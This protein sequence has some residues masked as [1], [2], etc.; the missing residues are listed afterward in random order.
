ML[1]WKHGEFDEQLLTDAV[2]D[3]ALFGEEEIKLQLNRQFFTHESNDLP[4]TKR[5]LFLTRP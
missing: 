1:N 4:T 3:A 5:G 2:L